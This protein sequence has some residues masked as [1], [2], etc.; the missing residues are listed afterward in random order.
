MTACP[1]SRRMRKIKKIWVI[2]R[3]SDGA[4]LFIY[5]RLGP[6]IPLDS[7]DLLR[8]ITLKVSDN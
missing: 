3:F 6:I 1:K 8:R 5:R 2:E 4:D 7:R